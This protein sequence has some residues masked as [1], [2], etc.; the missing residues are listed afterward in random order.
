MKLNKGFFLK[1]WKGFTYIC[2]FLLLFC[3]CAVDSVPNTP[4][5]LGIIL[6]ISE[7][8]TYEWFAGGGYDDF[9]EIIFRRRH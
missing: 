8:V 4:F 7:I 1:V 9:K 5:L 2:G 3:V 6:C